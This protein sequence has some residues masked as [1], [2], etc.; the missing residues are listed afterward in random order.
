MY[1]THFEPRQL[2]EAGQ[3]GRE[4]TVRRGWKD[5]EGIPAGGWRKGVHGMYWQNQTDCHLQ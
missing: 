3:K 2:A 5:S 4:E 1:S